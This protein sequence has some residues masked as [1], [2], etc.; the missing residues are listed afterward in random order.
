VVMRRVLRASTTR[1]DEGDEHEADTGES[2]RAGTASWIRLHGRDGEKAM[3]AQACKCAWFVQ[4]GAPNEHSNTGLSG[5]ELGLRGRRLRS[6]REGRGSVGRRFTDTCR[7]NDGRGER[8]VR[9]RDDA[10][11]AA[12][13]DCFAAML[14][15]GNLAGR[16]VGPHARCRT[17]GWGVRPLGYG[18]PVAGH[19][20][21]MLG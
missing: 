11:R 8:L 17:R 10:D 3:A 20:H 6:R 15:E 19:R 14:L 9:A 1:G 7:G 16:R 18:H 2:P 5:F 4:R 21:H 13:R 12:P